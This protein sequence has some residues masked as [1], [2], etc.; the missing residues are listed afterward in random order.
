MAAGG[1]S[2]SPPRAI[3]ASKRQP[4]VATA[5]P[6][7]AAPR[8]APFTS[9]PALRILQRPAHPHELGEV[10]RIEAQAFLHRRL[11]L[12]PERLVDE[13]D[14]AAGDDRDLAR[15][16]TRSNGRRGNALAQRQAGDRALHDQRPIGRIPSAAP[17]GS[18]EAMTLRSSAAAAPPASVASVTE[19][20]TLPFAPAARLRGVRPV[21]ARLATRSVRPPRTRLHPRPHPA[22]RATA[23]GHRATARSFGVAPG[24]SPCGR[25]PGRRR[26]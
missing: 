17:V 11:E 16:Q 5:T 22:P 25:G 9:T 4:A 3:G 23:T 19:T 8:T 21:E 12:E 2:S 13:V 20:M 7:L 14:V 26:Y 15:L 18:T 1:T 24:R 10:G 6:T